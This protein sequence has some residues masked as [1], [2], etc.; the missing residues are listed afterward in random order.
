MSTLIQTAKLTTSTRRP[1]S[2]GAGCSSTGNRPDRR[3]D[4]LTWQIVH[5]AALVGGLIIPM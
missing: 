2:S 3:Q 4:S 5:E 1:R